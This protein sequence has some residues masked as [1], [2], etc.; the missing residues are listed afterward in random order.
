MEQIFPHPTLWVALS[1]WERGEEV[2]GGN[3]WHI[4]KTFTKKK[5]IS[6]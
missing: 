5:I 4:Q 3:E 6:I 2:R 1:H